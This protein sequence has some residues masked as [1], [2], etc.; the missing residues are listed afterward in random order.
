MNRY[1]SAVSLLA[2]SLLTSLSI[3]AADSVELKVRGSVRPSA[4]VR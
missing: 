1:I 4:C 3:Q 2:V